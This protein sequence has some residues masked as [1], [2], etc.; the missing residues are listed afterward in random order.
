MSTKVLSRTTSH[1]LGHIFTFDSGVPLFNTFGVSPANIAM[2]HISSK[3]RLFA[4][5]DIF[6]AESMGHTGRLS[7][8]PFT[9]T[10]FG[11][12]RKPICDFLLVNHTNLYRILHR[13]SDIANYWP[14]GQKPDGETP[15]T[16]YNA[17]IGCRTTLRSYCQY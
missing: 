5:G 2:Y 7:L 3:T 16:R 12:E 14:D 1:I 6:V 15:H 13:F 11:T 4:L 8:T 9:V 10:D 17:N